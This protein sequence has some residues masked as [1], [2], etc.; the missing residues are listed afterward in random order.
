MTEASN[1]AGQALSGTETRPSGYRAAREV[2]FRA[3]VSRLSETPQERKALSRLDRIL[4]ANRPLRDDV[5]R[6]FHINIRV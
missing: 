2:Q 5:P 1:I 4:E 3:A 6:G